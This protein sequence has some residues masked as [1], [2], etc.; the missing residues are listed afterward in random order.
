V[1]L[2]V[3]DQAAPVTPPGSEFLRLVD[4]ALSLAMRRQIFTAEEA[5]DLL[6]GVRTKVHDGLVEDAL[7]TI[8]KT[9]GDS[10]R[11]TP[12]VDRARVIDPLLDMRLALSA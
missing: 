1:R 7:A 2:R 3:R 11:D 6:E 8:A 4:V 10:Y 12:L 5:I 9:A